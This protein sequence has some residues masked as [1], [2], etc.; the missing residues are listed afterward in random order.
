[1]N[2]S[3]VD[4][5]HLRR[6]KKSAMLALTLGLLSSSVSA[7]DLL[8][9]YQAALINDAS[10][11]AARAARTSGQEAVPQARAQMLPS[12]TAGY[13]RSKLSTES[14]SYVNLP[15]NQQDYFS[16]NQAITLRQPLLRK[17]LMAGYAQAKSRTEE[18]EAT[19]EKEQQNLAIR[20]AT[21][22]FDALLAME[23][24]NLI[25]TQKGSI[26][27]IL[28]SAKVA[29]AK[30]VGTRTDIDEAQARYDQVI[31]DELGARQNIDYTR[32]ELE[33]LINQKVDQLSHLLD[34]KFHFLLLEQTDLLYW[35]SQ[36]DDHNPDIKT[37][38]AQLGVAEQQIE[39][40]K[41]GHYPTVDLVLQR[42]M[43]SGES[44]TSPLNSYNT[45]SAGV[46]VSIPLFAG[47]Y[48]VSATRQAHA[49]KENIFQQLEST[50]RKVG[51]QVRKEFQNVTEGVFRI[52]AQEQAVHSAELSLDSMQKSMRAGVRSRLDVLNAQ[53]NQVNAKRD[54][55][56]ARFEYLLSHIRLHSLIGTVDREKIAQIN[57]LFSSK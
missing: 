55:A 50:R 26:K 12:L 2:A 9:S 19:F 29:F 3:G 22:Y 17:S 7:I 10:F 8:E 42:S 20:V 43:S 25:T 51:L 14:P 1:M 13:S 39:K 49:D 6:R 38:K 23:Q 16:Q 32:H 27:A 4:P 56:E 46:Q 52:K 21:A 5:K 45:T 35:Q 40:G 30:G 37:L 48:F 53:Q 34:E 47:G 28:E 54:L 15:G 33:T 41:A 11:L 24:L 57:Q 31:S 44:V 18:A 36:A